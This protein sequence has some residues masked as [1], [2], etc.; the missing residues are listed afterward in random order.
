MGVAKGEGVGVRTGWEIGV[1]RGK[2]FYIEW[3]NNKIL[4]CSIGT[5]SQYPIME[6]IIE[7]HILKT[8]CMDA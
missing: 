3:I 2:L 5:Y 1:S 7:K 6:T 8:V 4:L